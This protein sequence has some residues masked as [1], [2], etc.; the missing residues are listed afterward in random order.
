MKLARVH[1][2]ILPI[3]LFFSSQSYADFED[4]FVKAVPTPQNA[5]VIKDGSTQEVAN[6]PNVEDQDSL[7]TCHGFSSACVLQE[8]LCSQR[9]WDCQNLP[10][11]KKVSGL[12]MAA[13]DKQS[14]A[15]DPTVYDNYKAINLEG[16]GASD[17]LNSVGLAKKTYSNACHPFDQIVSKFSGNERAM[18]EFFHKL[19]VD[20]KYAAPE[21]GQKTEGGLCSDCLVKDAAMLNVDNAKMLAAIK[22]VHDKTFDQ[23]LYSIFLDQ[24]TDLLAIVP[25][26][27]VHIFPNN[28]DKQPSNY[29]E[30]IAKIHDF[31]STSKHPINL[32]GVCL[33]GTATNCTE[34]HSVVI[35]G[36]R[37]ICKAGNVDCHE[38]LK[39]QNSWGK[40]WQ[41]EYDGGWVDAKTLL[42]TTGYNN[43]ILSWLTPKGA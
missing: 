34:R 11:T 42:D 7:G 31:L 15:G 26:A 8:Y 1:L 38:S 25:K 24:C 20:A 3:A 40:T 21:P 29:K 36:Y 22:N 13:F 43:G 18:S 27:E 10:D 33:I 5:L 32:D 17:L 4:I 16:S 23:F 35:A 14:E 9:Q 41:N 39:I 37:E 19:E 30:T 12:G 2:A 28:P 6:M